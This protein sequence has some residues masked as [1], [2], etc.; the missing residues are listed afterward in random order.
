MVIDH[1]TPNK[2]Q[3]LINGLLTLSSSNKKKP[4]HLRNITKS[5]L[6]N[7]QNGS[8]TELTINIQFDY[9]LIK[10]DLFSRFALNV[11]QYILYDKQAIP[12]PY[13][14]RDKLHQFFPNESSLN[15]QQKQKA[16]KHNFNKLKLTF[17]F[18]DKLFKNS[19]FKIH[20]FALTL[21]DSLRFA[22][23]VFII[24]HSELNLRCSKQDKNPCPFLT[25]RYMI[26]SFYSRLLNEVPEE[27]PE[28]LKSFNSNKQIK[29]P[30]NMIF[31]VR[32]AT[33]LFNDFKEFV[34]S[35]VNENSEDFKAEMFS[36]MTG[37]H[38]RRLGSVISR[39]T[40]FKFSQYLK[41]RQSIKELDIYLEDPEI[42][43]EVI[44]EKLSED[45]L[46]IVMEE[47]QNDSKE[48][49]EQLNEPLSQLNQIDQVLPVAKKSPLFDL[50]EEPYVWVQIT[51]PIKCINKL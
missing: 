25:L 4:L 27:Q 37:N 16:L 21:G 7:A 35:Y 1:K 32:I 15:K 17:D 38:M 43:E 22:Q 33:S 28:N 45:S 50:E 51:P 3:R 23:D 31:A 26:D 36:L 47:S 44:E 14:Y 40:N 9:G 18:I 39:V 13:F 49:G 6:N 2:L 11:V 46:M 20:S 34:D 12:I 19:K 30:R 24:D 42:I 41:P 10:S 5:N 8:N 48:N 29:S